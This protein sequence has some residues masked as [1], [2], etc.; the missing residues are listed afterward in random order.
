[1]KELLLLHLL[2][3]T[4]TTTATDEVTVTMPARTNSRPPLPKLLASGPSVVDY[5]ELKIYA[6]FGCLAL[7]DAK[8]RIIKYLSCA[9]VNAKYP[10]FN[11]YDTS[12][13]NNVIQRFKT[14]HQNTSRD[15]AAAGRVS[16][17]RK[18]RHRQR[19]HRLPPP[20]F[21]GTV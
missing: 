14:Q 8:G 4:T 1:L 5:N 13:V 3:P 21:A 2:Q 6:Q 11:K 10:Q 19:H 16:A 20:L 12:S 9:E 7:K 15:R 17:H 18:C